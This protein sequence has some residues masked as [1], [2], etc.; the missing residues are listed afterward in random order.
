MFLLTNNLIV[1]CTFA[2]FLVVFSLMVTTREIQVFY[3]QSSCRYFHLD[4]LII[5]RLLELNMFNQCI[6]MI[7][8]NFMGK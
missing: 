7:N 6:S 2:P 5:K 1:A 3:D 4:F 8:S